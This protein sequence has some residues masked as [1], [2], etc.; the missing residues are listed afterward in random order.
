MR[1]F[2][3]WQLQLRLSNYDNSTAETSNYDNS[4]DEIS[5]YNNSNNEMSN[6]DISNDK[7]SNSDISKYDNSN[8]NNSNYYFNKLK[9]LLLVALQQKIIT[10]K[11]ISNSN[12]DYL[13]C[14]N[15]NYDRPIKY[16]HFKFN[17]FNLVTLK[18]C[19]F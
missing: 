13:N 11:F 7:I 12:Y 19:V 9:F 10:N 16:W 1:Q 8:F 5:N 2:K 17:S 18:L 14:Y 4:N 15:L 6:S 3:C